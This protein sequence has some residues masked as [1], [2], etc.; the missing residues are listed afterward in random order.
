LPAPQEAPKGSDAAVDVGT[1]EEFCADIEIT[2]KGGGRQSF[3]PSTWNLSQRRLHRDRTGRDITL[4]GRQQ[5]VSTYELAQDLYTAVKLTGVHVLAITHDD[6]TAR[7]FHQVWST[8]MVGLERAKKLPA[9]ETD[10]VGEIVFAGTGSTLRVTVAGATER[11]A[12]K[13]GRGRALERLHCTEVS[14]WGAAQTTLDAATEGV[15]PGGQVVLESTAYGAS[16]AFY[17]QWKR[18][19]DPSNPFRRHFLPWWWHREYRVP[20]PHDFDALPRDRHE[21]A[22]RELG[23]DDE[24]LAWWRQKVAARPDVEALLQQYPYA[25]AVA[26]RASGGNYIDGATCDWLEENAR[27]PIR[28]VPLRADDGRDL[29][30]LL[31]YEEPVRGEAYVAGGDV[32]E[33][34]GPNGDASAW[35]FTHRRTGLTVATWWS[36]RHEPADMALAGAQIGKLYNLALLAPE[37][38]NHG[39]TVIATLVRVANY[40]C[41]YEHEDGKLGWVTSPATRPLLFDEQADA[42]R[43][44]TL[45]TSDRR[46]A[47]EARTLTRVNGKPQARG[48]GTAGGARDDAFVAHAIGTQV[49]LRKPVTGRAGSHDAV[50]S[51]TADMDTRW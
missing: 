27:D 16:G 24:Q 31:V 10:R 36:D 34:L 47:A 21:E 18:A 49:R 7:T 20:V 13:K 3:A 14:H 43:R 30:E 38:N 39:G 50:R 2:L 17:D 8:M 44:R 41:I 25:A 37:R 1:F 51:E 33:G 11:T 19:D 45:P 5:G 26:F 28:R 4:K 15:R 9:T 12:S 46:V 35:D 6:D 48:K 42:W 22:M 32:A 40:P 23:L 29:G